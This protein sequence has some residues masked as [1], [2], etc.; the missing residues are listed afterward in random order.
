MA[1]A[2]LGFQTSNTSM[3]IRWSLFSVSVHLPTLPDLS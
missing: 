2:T 3:P 1:C